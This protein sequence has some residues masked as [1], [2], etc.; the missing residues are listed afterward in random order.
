M[1]SGKMSGW[2]VCVCV[3]REGRIA[4]VRLAQDVQQRTDARAKAVATRI[5]TASSDN[6]TSKLFTAFEVRAL[7][8]AEFEA[9]PTFQRRFGDL[10]AF[11]KFVHSHALP[12]LEG[13]VGDRNRVYV[14]DL[15]YLYNEF[16]H[17]RECV[18]PIAH[19]ASKT[20]SLIYH[21]RTESEPA[22]LEYCLARTPPLA[23]SLETAPEEAPPWERWSS[24]PWQRKSWHA[25]HR[26]YKSSRSHDGRAH[27]AITRDRAAAPASLRCSQPVT[28]RQS[29]GANSCRS[30]PS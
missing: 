18:G 21:E 14:S 6:A 15:K 24:S 29:T 17:V 25:Q 12:I 19:V 2:M 8:V 23:P 16:P 3:L 11:E 22:R 10:A 13:Y 20:E 7:V 28:P 26:H 5:V 9:T 4:Q 30:S 1:G 27:G